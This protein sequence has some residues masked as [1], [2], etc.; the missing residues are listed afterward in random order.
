M[1]TVYEGQCHCNN[2]DCQILTITIRNHCWINSKSKDAVYTSY[3][4]TYIKVTTRSMSLSRS[5]E[6]AFN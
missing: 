2:S 3:M 5:Y 1:V 6:F 4:N